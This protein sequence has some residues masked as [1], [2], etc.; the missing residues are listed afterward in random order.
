MQVGIP[1]QWQ[2][3]AAEPQVAGPQRLPGSSWQVPLT[4][5]VY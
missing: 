3:D 1:L 5:Q 2:H 4:T